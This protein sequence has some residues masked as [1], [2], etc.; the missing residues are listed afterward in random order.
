MK[1]A[2]CEPLE[3]KNA[4]Q[5][6]RDF[7]RIRCPSK[8]GK[9]LQSPCSVIARP[10]LSNQKLRRKKWFAERPKTACKLEVIS[11][12]AL[13]TR[14][15]DWRAHWILLINAM[16][17]RFYYL[18]PLMIEL[19]WYSHVCAWVHLHVCKQPRAHRMHRLHRTRERKMWQ[20]R[21][22][23]KER[24]QWKWPCCNKIER[25]MKMNLGIRRFAETSNSI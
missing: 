4:V 1:L 13:T 10:A 5:I 15:C 25:K 6:E 18:H 11:L 22:G 3:P 20:W 24:K 17:R 7:N 9:C 12:N 23:K 21:D 14:T 8:T 2:Q 16:P 19:E